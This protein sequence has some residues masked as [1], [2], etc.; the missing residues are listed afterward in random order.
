MDLGRAPRQNVP[1]D[2]FGS[3]NLPLSTFAITRQHEL[4][5]LMTS[6]NSAD[7]ITHPEHLSVLFGQLRSTDANP[8]SSFFECFPSPR[9]YEQRRQRLNTSS[10]SSTASLSTY[11]QRSAAV[12][13]QDFEVEPEH[14]DVR[15]VYIPGRTSHHNTNPSSS[16][17]EPGEEDHT[18]SPRGFFTVAPTEEEITDALSS[19]FAFRSTPVSSPAVTPRIESF[20]KQQMIH[21]RLLE[22]REEDA[23]LK[24]EGSA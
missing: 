7:T 1:L 12:A 10:S 16:A 3:V 20:C 22:R 19:P 2:F 24:Q 11:R 15:S 23:A 17:D 6:S 5:S 8:R 21:P 9:T 4:P 14:E 18:V 13:D